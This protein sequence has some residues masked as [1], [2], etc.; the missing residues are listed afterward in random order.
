MNFNVNV[1]GVVGRFVYFALGA[2]VATALIYNF[3]V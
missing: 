3:F 2:S 1:N